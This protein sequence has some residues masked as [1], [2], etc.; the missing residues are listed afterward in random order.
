M[1]K[2]SNWLLI[3][4]YLPWFCYFTYWWLFWVL[5]RLSRLQ[6]VI[7]LC[8]RSRCTL[9]R[10]KICERITIIIKVQKQ[11]T[12]RLYK[13]SNKLKTQS[14]TVAVW[15]KV[16]GY[17]TLKGK[18]PAPKN[19]WVW[20]LRKLCFKI[21]RVKM[22]LK[23]KETILNLWLWKDLRSR[24]YKVL[25]QLS[26]MKWRDRTSHFFLAVFAIKSYS[27]TNDKPASCFSSPSYSPICAFPV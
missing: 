5:S 4:A 11:L 15:D 7:L 3:L 20:L 2:N 22:R 25:I 6:I 24:A 12:L 26:L 10:R 19:A 17:T 8:G 23:S 18:L 1:T 14:I 21:L 13:I 9:M 16:V 27:T